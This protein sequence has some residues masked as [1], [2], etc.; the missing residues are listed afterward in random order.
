ML[1]TRG[2]VLYHGPGNAAKDHFERQG[3]TCPL[4]YNV[5]DFL[6]DM[7]VASEHRDQQLAA[8]G[9]E[10]LNEPESPRTAKPLLDMHRDDSAMTALD[11]DAALDSTATTTALNATP[12]RTVS[13]A[14]SSASSAILAMDS[15]YQVSYLT[16]VT[17]LLARNGKCLVR[18]P[19]LLIE[20]NVLARDF[21]RDYWAALFPGARDDCGVEERES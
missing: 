10:A 19:R 6:L 16:Q 15:G 8:V 12:A 21:G 18:N 17:K 3:H 14:S 5:A 11:A 2:R 20:H 7:A 1:L 13:D 4:Y 9:I